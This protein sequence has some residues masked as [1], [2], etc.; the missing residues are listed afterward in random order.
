MLIEHD[1]PGFYVLIE[2]SDGSGKSV[3]SRA[4]VNALAIANLSSLQTAEPMYSMYGELIRERFKSAKEADAFELGFAF[5][6]DR[7]Y[8]QNHVV[9]PALK[10]GT[11]V[12]QDR[13]AISTLVYQGPVFGDD[14]H[15]L[16]KNVIKPDLIVLLACDEEAFRQRRGNGSNLYER[17]GFEGVKV[18]YY[19]HANN[20][21]GL[22]DLNFYYTGTGN[23]SM[24]PD[25]I[26]WDLVTCIQEMKGAKMAVLNDDKAEKVVKVVMNNDAPVLITDEFDL[27][28]RRTLVKKRLMDEGMGTDDAE[29]ECLKQVPT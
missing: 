9:V 5:A 16:N 26:A 1:Y 21:F 10:V 29:A 11:T 8:H 28:W 4:L 7:Q 14:V 22:D 25:E 3:L 15:I 17:M 27:F 18:E 23:G 13:G 19:K 2:G 20:L 12:V 6:A 24:A